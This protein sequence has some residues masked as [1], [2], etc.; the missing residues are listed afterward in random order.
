MLSRG[1]ELDPPGFRINPRNVREQ[2]AQPLLL[3]Q[4]PPDRRGDVARRK[5]RGRDLIQ[6]R[7]KD[8]VIVAIDDR[9]LARHVAEAAR[10]VEAGKPAADDDHLGQACHS[11]YSRYTCLS[12]G[13]RR[14][15]PRSRPPARSTAPM[16]A[17]WTSPSAAAA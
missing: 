15:N 4:D 9:H 10:G 16:R 14:L 12:L 6:Q 7:L 1:G 11:L 13:L 8:V 5:S 17:R 3:A 2:D